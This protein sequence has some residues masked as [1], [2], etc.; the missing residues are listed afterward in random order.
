MIG[1]TRVAEVLRLTLKYA[2]VDEVLALSLRYG[3]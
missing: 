1:L 3:S 2:A